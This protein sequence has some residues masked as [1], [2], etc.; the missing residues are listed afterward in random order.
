MS[1][2]TI[3]FSFTLKDIDDCIAEQ[4]IS[5]ECVEQKLST[6]T[7]FK[8]EAARIIA[9]YTKPPCPQC[10]LWPAWI[11]LWY[12]I[13]KLGQHSDLSQFIIQVSS[14]RGKHCPQYNC[15]IADNHDTKAVFDTPAGRALIEQQNEP[16]KPNTTIGT[17][18]YQSNIGYADYTCLDDSDDEQDTHDADY[19]CGFWAV[20]SK[21]LLSKE[22]RRLYSID[23]EQEYSEDISV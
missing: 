10:N 6:E 19:T 14:Q 1:T 22:S 20:C 12:K 21:T 15:S 16:T 5:A 13:Y 2:E 7:L 18:S 9:V 11:N 3:I 4:Y 23:E 17:N 8:R